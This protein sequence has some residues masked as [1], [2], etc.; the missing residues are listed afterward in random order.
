MI[1][2]R[3]RDSCAAVAIH[4]TTL[5]PKIRLRFQAAPLRGLG[6]VKWGGP[7]ETLR[8]DKGAAWGSGFCHSL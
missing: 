4:R 2:R 7:Y 6:V 5:Y 3:R 8:N 1:A